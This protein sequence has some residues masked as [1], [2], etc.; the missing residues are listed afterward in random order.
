MRRSLRY[1]PAALAVGLLLSLPLAGHAS[2]DRERRA[3]ER[4]DAI[5]SEIQAVSRR[6]ETTR[7]D[8][9]DADRALREVETAL[10]DTHRRLDTLQ[11]ERREVADEI[12]ELERQRGVLEAERDAQLEALA[13][14]L[15]A[16]Y[17]LGHTPQLKLLLNQDDP[18]RLDRLQ[19]Y[20]NHLSRAR[21]ERLDAIAALDERLVENQASLDARDAELAA[22]GDE[23]AER[24]ADLAEQMQ[25]REALVASLDAR[26]ASEQQR[27]D[28][29]D[30]DRD[31]AERVLQQ[32]R[33][34]M[35]RL[36][37]PPP[38]TA[39]A[40]TQGDLPWPVQGSVTSSFGRGDGI[41]RNG[42]LIQ[43][44]EGT[45]VTAV[46]SGRVVFADWMR[47]FGNL[48]IV[49]H[50]DQV[51]TLHAHLQHFSAEVGSAVSRGDVLGAVGN[52]GGQ[53]RSALYFEVRRNGEPIDPQGWIAQR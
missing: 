40:E 52:S 47:G 31:D 38:S 14:Q 27:L 49:D 15:E 5:G 9:D 43:A 45:P 39:I 6:L 16:L 41:S 35:A 36:S 17:R 24:S 23:L 3:E 7:E 34:E 53:G 33:E 20:L 21:N 1:G 50:G 22:L 25:E 29:L 12:D 48:L 42:M 2:E 11:A 18:A 51:M 4:L 13:T 8:R 44:G 46:H 37:E 28:G 32:V 30:R 10:A 26:Y 19:T